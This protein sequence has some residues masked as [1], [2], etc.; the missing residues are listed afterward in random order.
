MKCGTTSLA[1]WLDDLPQVVMTRPKEPGFFALDERWN[2]G[3][4]WYAGLFS[5]AREGQ[6][7][8]EASTNYTH[9]DMAERAADRILRT[10]P[11]V[12]LICLLRHPIDRLRSHYRDR[13]LWG[14]ESRGLV[15]ALSAP[16]STYIRHSKYFSCLTPYLS[17]FSRDQICV[18]TTEDLGKSDGPSWEAVL[19]HLNIPPRPHSSTSHNVS[20]ELGED[21]RLMRRIRSG[22]VNEL[23][24]RIPAPVRRWG[25]SLLSRRGRGFTRT[26]DESRSEIPEEL[27]K[28]VWK[29]VALLEDWLGVDKPLWERR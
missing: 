7:A 27:L 20:A 12:R 23:L 10:V 21:G 5:T 29:D 22:P 11:D 24:P 6:T 26:L 14:G 19:Q 25:R 13:R 18:A 3:L 1:E 28:S 16:N 4:E 8:G 15:A 9:P 17:R 2:R